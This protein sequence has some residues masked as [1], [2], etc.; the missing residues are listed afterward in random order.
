LGVGPIFSFGVG[1]GGGVGGGCATV[2]LYGVWGAG[3]WS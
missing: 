2:R 1:G 3:R